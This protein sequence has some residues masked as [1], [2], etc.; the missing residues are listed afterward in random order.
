MATLL[1]KVFRRDVA[2]KCTVVKGEVTK[3]EIEPLDKESGK[4]MFEDKVILCY[5]R[6]ESG[7]E[8]FLTVDYYYDEYLLDL[9]AYYPNIE[10]GTDYPD[11]EVG[12]CIDMVEVPLE[13]YN[14]LLK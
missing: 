8:D 12:H 11:V 14:K 13:I 4:K 1:T 3:K 5:L 9:Y 10:Y 6:I 7:S 2:K